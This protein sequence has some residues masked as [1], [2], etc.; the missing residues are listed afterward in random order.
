G[1]NRPRRIIKVDIVRRLRWR[2]DRRWDH[3]RSAWDNHHGKIVEPRR[4]VNNVG[5]G[6]PEARDSRHLNS[7]PEMKKKADLG[8]TPLY[9]FL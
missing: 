9:L 1:W 5:M 3:P 6:P 8:G 2:A 4:A 7:K